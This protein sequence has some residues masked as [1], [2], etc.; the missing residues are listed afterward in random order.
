MK[1]VTLFALPLLAACASAACAQTPPPLSVSLGVFSPTTSD[2]RHRA[3][4]TLVLGALRYALPSQAVSTSR[5]V[6]EGTA[7]YGKKGSESSVIVSLTGGQIFSLSS[8]KSPLSAQTG[9]LGLGGGLYGMDLSGRHTFGRVGVYGEAGYN[10]TQ[11][12]FAQVSYRLVDQGS[13]ASLALG[14]R[15]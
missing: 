1:S 3:G 7:A 11:A 8:G 9:Y 2:T 15:F 6:A 12:V 13:G 14:T 10:F 5:T 4:S